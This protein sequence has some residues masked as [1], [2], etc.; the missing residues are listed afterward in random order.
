MFEHALG[1]IGIRSNAALLMQ[2]QPEHTAAQRIGKFRQGQGITGR[3]GEAVFSKE[4]VGDAVLHNVFT[5]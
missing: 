1:T 3:K 4:E 5:D 2:G